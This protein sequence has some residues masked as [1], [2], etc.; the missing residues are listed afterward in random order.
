MLKNVPVEEKSVQEFIFI[1]FKKRAI[2]R[3]RVSEVK[4]NEITHSSRTQYMT[5]FFISELDLESYFLS[6]ENPFTKKNLRKKTFFL[7]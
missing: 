4:I 6:V 3:E 1:P 5:Q 7:G 2:W